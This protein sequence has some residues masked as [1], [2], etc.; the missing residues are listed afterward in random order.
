M[1][2]ARLIRASRRYSTV[3]V[4]LL[5]PCFSMLS[6]VRQTVSISRVRRSEVLYRVLSG[7]LEL[8]RTVSFMI[9]SPG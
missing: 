9:T 3:T 1:G 8:Y 5:Y 2:P 4:P 6:L 7:Y